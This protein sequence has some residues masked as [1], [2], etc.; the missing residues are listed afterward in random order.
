M[1]ISENEKINKQF[2]MKKNIKS[3]LQHTITVEKQVS[4]KTIARKDAEV[5]IF[6]KK[7]LIEKKKAKFKNLDDRCGDF[8]EFSV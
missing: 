7:K 3:E 5:S 2:E 8:I 6:Q 4:I 1:P